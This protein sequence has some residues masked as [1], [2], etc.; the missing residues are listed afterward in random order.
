MT[1]QKTKNISG[2][3]ECPSGRHCGFVEPQREEE[4][5][6]EKRGGPDKIWPLTE[7]ESQSSCSNMSKSRVSLQLATNY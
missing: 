2:V 3:K 5:R 7:N 4:K 6:E 1:K